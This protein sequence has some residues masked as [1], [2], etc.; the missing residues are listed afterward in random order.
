MDY[1]VIFGMVVAAS[2][3]LS[4]AVIAI[5]KMSMSESKPIQDLNVSITK[6]NSN[7]EHMVELDKTR[8]E[9]IKKHGEQID[10]IMNNQKNN[11]KVLDRHELRIGR[12]EEYHKVSQGA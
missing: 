7:I 6:L 9:R 1:Y 4:G 11:E 10:A 5:K 8:D 2:I 3:A 12:L